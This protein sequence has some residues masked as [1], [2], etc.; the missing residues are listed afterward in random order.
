[1]LDDRSLKNAVK[2]S[3]RFADGHATDHELREIRRAAASCST[4]LYKA[5]FPPARASEMAPLNWAASAVAAASPQVKEAVRGAV[6]GPLFL[7]EE[8]GQRR[9]YGAILNHIIGNPFRPHLI[10]DHWP[11][12]VVQLADALYG[13]EK[14][15]FALHDALLESGHPVLADHFRQDK[16]HPKGCWALDLIL[17]KS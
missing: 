16:R 14:C 4:A 11:S 1:L 10:P 5:T 13:G 2:I 17:G 6:W 7:E 15:G 8:A 9:I 3:E 12:N